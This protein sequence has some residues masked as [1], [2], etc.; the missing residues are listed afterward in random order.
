[1]TIG[2]RL[3][4]SRKGEQVGTDEYGNRYFKE[5]GVSMKES[6]RWALFDGEPE[7]SKIPADWHRWLHKVTDELP[8]PNRRKLAW[9]QPHLAN[10][11]G[12]PAA[13]RPQGH[14]LV[15]GPRAAATGDYQAWRPE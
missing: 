15:G 14:Q 1:M 6:R 3:F 5:K 7:A 9:E 4:T 13:H 2:T 11:T 10:Q 8:D 12:T